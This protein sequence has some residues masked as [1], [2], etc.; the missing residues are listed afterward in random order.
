MAD[1]VRAIWL[2][3]VTWPAFQHSVDHDYDPAAGMRA[4]MTPLLTD[5]GRAVLGLS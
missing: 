3:G 5:A 1:L 4:I 2:L